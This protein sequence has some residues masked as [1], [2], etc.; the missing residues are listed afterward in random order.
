MTIGHDV[1]IAKQGSESALTVADKGLNDTLKNLMHSTSLLASE[2]THTIGN[3]FKK[4]RAKTASQ[5]I[6]DAT[7]AIISEIAIPPA[8]PTIPED[9]PSSDNSTEIPITKE[10]LG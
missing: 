9:V 8:N 7:P 10:P 5:T 2:T 1:I 6:P 4:D 3:Y